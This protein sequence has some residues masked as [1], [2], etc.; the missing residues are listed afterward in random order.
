MKS[1]T[2]SCATALAICETHIPFMIWNIATCWG[3]APCA[4][5]SCPWA[6]G[7]C[8]SW[9]CAGSTDMF[10]SSQVEMLVGLARWPFRASRQPGHQ[11]DEAYARGAVVDLSLHA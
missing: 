7:E 6:V 10:F 11:L 4:T 3:G 1:A 8:G 5:G 2:P 9:L